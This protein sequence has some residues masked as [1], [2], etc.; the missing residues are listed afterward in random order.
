MFGNQLSC[1][2]II[3]IFMS[4]SR[5]RCRLCALKRA[6]HLRV[7]GT[8]G[9]RSGNEVHLGIASRPSVPRIAIGCP[10]CTIIKVRHRAAHCI[11]QARS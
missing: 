11:Y 3:C 2:L 10:K 8:L 9:R 5:L 6:F 4:V 7:G 1:I